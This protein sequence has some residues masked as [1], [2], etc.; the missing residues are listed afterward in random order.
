MHMTP[1]WLCQPAPLSFNIFRTYWCIMQFTLDLE[2][3]TTS[4]SW[5][6]LMWMPLIFLD[7]Q[8]FLD[9]LKGLYHV[10]TLFFPYVPTSPGWRTLFLCFRELKEDWQDV[11]VSFLMGRNFNRSNKSSLAWPNFFMCTL[12][13]PRGVLDQINKY[14]D[15]AFGENAACKI[16]VLP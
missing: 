8:P 16:R 15:I 9:A 12:E 4:Q 10:N 11:I 13:L 14:L 1:S 6:Q 2:L 5:S 3:I 7:S